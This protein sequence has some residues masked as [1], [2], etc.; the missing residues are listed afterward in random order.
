MGRAIR[1]AYVLFL[2]G[3][4]AGC[5]SGARCPCPAPAPGALPT[6]EVM[7]MPSP[8][9][10]TV[11]AGT[12]ATVLDDASGI[13]ETTLPNGLRLLVRPQPDNPVCACMIWYSV[14][15]RDEDVGET[16]L[17]HYLEHM[18]FKGTDKYPKG[19]IDKVTQKN[20]GSNNASTR[21][22]CTDAGDMNAEPIDAATYPEPGAPRQRILNK[23]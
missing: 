6:R 17:S 2:A 16:G 5:A 22:D 4:A 13:S 21:N 8:A 18:Q 14:G 23:G 11:A 19:A 12:A 1:A 7:P 20:G 9:Q 3:V 15:A 10:T